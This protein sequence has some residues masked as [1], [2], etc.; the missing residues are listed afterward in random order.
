M[1]DRPDPRETDRLKTSALFDADWYR[2]TYRDVAMT[3]MDPAHHYMRYGFLMDRDPGPDF[4]TSINRTALRDIKPTQE[5]L[6]VLQKLRKASPDAPVYDQ[7]NVLPAAY[8]ESQLGSHDRAIA[9]A[10]AHLPPAAAHTLH[11]LRANRAIA[12]ATRPVGRRA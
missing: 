11:V 4:S 2:A 5:P 10:T 8:K 3:G 12:W 7:R 9:L 1:A 6:T